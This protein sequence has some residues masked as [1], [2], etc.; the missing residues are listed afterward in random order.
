LHKKG[1]Y[2]K[3]KAQK[4][5]GTENKVSGPNFHMSMRSFKTATLQHIDFIPEEQHFNPKAYKI[6]LRYYLQLF[7]PN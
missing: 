5:E 1:F 4:Y 6:H 2:D 7:S 3:Y